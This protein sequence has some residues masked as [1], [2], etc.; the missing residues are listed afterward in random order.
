MNRTE[1][2]EQY[3][4]LAKQALALAQKARREGLLA[5]ES[6][7]EKKN[8]EERDI[9]EYGLFF[10]VDGTDG[11]LIA[12]ILDNIINQEKDEYARIIKT[13]QREAVLGIQQGDN[14]KVLFY[15]MNSLT[16]IPLKDDKA[17]AIITGN[18][19]EG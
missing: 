8:I 9:L 11:N 4:A 18:S 6:S 1:F 17:Y 15:K 14:P 10:V 3:T 5:L 7:L 12:Q 2:V 19:Q 16:D 13:I